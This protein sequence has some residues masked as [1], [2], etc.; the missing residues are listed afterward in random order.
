MIFFSAGFLAGSSKW[1]PHHGAW[2]RALYQSHGYMAVRDRYR[3][4][5]AA[6]MRYPVNLG[7]VQAAQG[8]IVHSEH[9]R[10]LASEWLGRG[11]ADDWKVI[12]QLRGLADSMATCGGTGRRSACRRT[13]FILCSFG[14]LDPVKLNHRLIEAFM[15]SSLVRDAKCST[16]F[17]RGK[18]RWRLWREAAG[19]NPREWAFRTYPH[20]RL[21]GSHWSSA[22]IWPPPIWPFKCAPVRAAKHPERCW[23][24]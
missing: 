8:V 3:D 5:E 19:N 9:A 11:F 1:T 18:S 16:D 12:P 14:L 4:A 17:R 6:K 13:H 24:A 20:H 7:I 21:D 23:I 10:M 15:A 22:S 2:T